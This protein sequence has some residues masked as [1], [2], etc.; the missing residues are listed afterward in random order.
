MVHYLSRL[1]SGVHLRGWRC[2]ENKRLRLPRSVGSL[3]KNWGR[4]RLKN[5]NMTNRLRLPRRTVT[6]AGVTYLCQSRGGSGVWDRGG[7]LYRLRWFIHFTFFY[8]SALGW[9]CGANLL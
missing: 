4:G 1:G 3:R 6:H 5:N 9:R 7:S 8:G 2:G